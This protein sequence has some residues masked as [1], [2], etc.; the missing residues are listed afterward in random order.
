M[1]IKNSI[2]FSLT[3]L[4]PSMILWRNYK[5][6]SVVFHCA[7]MKFPFKETLKIPHKVQ[8]RYLH[9]TVLLS[10]CLKNKTYGSTLYKIMTLKMRKNR[11]KYS[12]PKIPSDTYRWRLQWSTMESKLLQFVL[13]SQILS[14]TKNLYRK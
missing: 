5:Q 13:I 14:K 12:K 2:V 3:K 4:T 7:L 8:T 10:N 6:N 9:K 11:I 1:Q